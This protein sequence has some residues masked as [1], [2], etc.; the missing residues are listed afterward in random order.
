MIEP[1]QEVLEGWGM[2]CRSS[3]WVYRPRDAAEA[4]AAVADARR[5]GLTIAHRGA[6]QSYGDAALNADGAVIDCSA[7]DR[8]LAFDRETGTVRAEAG[9]TIGQLWQHVLSAGFWPPVVP[10]TMAVTLGGAA[11]MN[12]HGKNAFRVGP[13]GEHVEA[14]TLLGPDGSAREI[15]RDAASPV[16]DWVR[17]EG[18][19]GT[20]AGV[21]PSTGPLRLTEVLGAQGLNGTILDVTLKLKHVASGFLQ[22]TPAP[23]RTLAEALDLV[24]DAARAH[25]YAVGWLDCFAGGR[26]LGRGALHWAD[27]LPP[28]HRLAGKGLDPAEQRLPDRILG[29]VP[30]RHTWR[31]LKPFNNAIGMRAMNAAKQWAGVVQGRRPYVQGHAGF[32]FLLDYVPDWKRVYRPHGLAQYQLFVPAAAAEGILGEALRL[33]HR[34]GVVSHLCV[35]KRHRPDAFAGSYA[36]DGYSLALDF[37]V[38]PRRLAAMRSLFEEFDCLLAG[39]GGRIYAAK[40]QFSVGR[41]PERRDPAYSTE[42][43]RRWE[44]GA[45]GR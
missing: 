2:S 36:V 13:F 32:H 40:D 22:V 7:L 41:L 37:P 26:S 11:A 10:G 17:A 16:A 44:A 3:A 24:D 9:V 31:A 6:G 39:C 43:A 8:I 19:P 5:R 45:A 35:L 29:V 1:R 23:V 27:H 33:Q 34:L 28:D 18:A 38:R 42:L 20:S 12:I 4:A 25:D 21:A 30:K 15:R 14:V